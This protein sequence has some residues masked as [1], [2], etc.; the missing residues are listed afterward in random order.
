MSVFSGTY[1]LPYDLHVDKGSVSSGTVAGMTL[2]PVVVDSEDGEVDFYFSMWFREPYEARYIQLLLTS[3]WWISGN[4]PRCYWQVLVWN[5]VHSRWEQTP[6]VLGDVSGVD[7]LSG[8]KTGNR[9]RCPLYSATPLDGPY[10]QV[11]HNL[12]L[13]NPETGATGSPWITESLTQTITAEHIDGQGRAAIRLKAWPSPWFDHEYQVSI[14]AAF[15]CRSNFPLP[16]AYTLELGG[17]FREAYRGIYE[18]TW[19]PESWLSWFGVWK[20]DLPDNGGQIKFSWCWSG[21]FFA[22]GDMER[23]KLET[24]GASKVADINNPDSW[25]SQA[26]A[27][28]LLGQP[29][30]GHAVFVLQ[31]LRDITTSSVRDISGATLVGYDYIQWFDGDTGRRTL[32]LSAGTI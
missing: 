5:F 4:T 26:V 24:W 21:S 28:L 3:F 11:G 13:S 29:Y 25:E 7:G 14:R 8:V 12:W 20:Y 10:V 32:T 31:L 19:A 9:R 2:A 17:T 6:A 18:L 15:G 27:S 30:N 1:A 16:R 22:L 23:N